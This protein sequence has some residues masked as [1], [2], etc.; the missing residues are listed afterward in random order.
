MTAP[1]TASP[2]TSPDL[3]FAVIVTFRSADVVEALALAMNGW[4]T[5]NPNT[6]L[7]VLDNSDSQQTI[8]NVHS[9]TRTNAARVIAVV[10]GS[11]TGFAPAVNV[12]VEMARERWGQPATVV[13]VNPD[14]LTDAATLN[15]VPRL[16]DDPTI[17]IAAPLL[18]DADG[19]DTDRGV[20]RRFWNRRLLFAEV[21][22]VPEIATVL[23]S[24]S[25]NISVQPGDGLIDVDITSGAFMAIRAEV[26]G[27]GLD[28][29]LPMYL[30]DQEICHRA[31][32]RGLRVVVARHVVARHVG[33]ASRRSNTA[34]AQQLL[35]LIHI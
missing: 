6:R 12:A 26:F 29:R 30:E 1:S 35:S 32:R 19:R 15:Q 9:I 28:V 24:R 16:L 13:L 5:E 27:N 11:N 8:D 3:Q 33:A 10:N 23:A 31:A 4:L 25:R 14:V 7:V 21:L 20:A 22:G 34:M 18:L 2:D 17:G